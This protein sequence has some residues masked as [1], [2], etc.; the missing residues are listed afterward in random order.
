MIAQVKEE[1]RQDGRLM[2]HTR[3]VFKVVRI[4]KD[5][6][7]GT[8]YRPAVVYDMSPFENM[9]YKPHSYYN[10]GVE[11]MYPPFAYYNE[12]DAREFLNYQCAE[13][14]DGFGVISRVA[15][16]W[17]W[18][19][20]YLAFTDYFTSDLDTFWNSVFP[21]ARIPRQAPPTYPVP[22]GSIVMFE[23]EI[24]DRVYGG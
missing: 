24:G 9:I 16:K 7:N 20:R 2:E 21:Y 6:N 10:I 11:F 17:A 5:Y 14:K 19:R 8:I 22:T 3:T 13:D 12:I 4:E 23:F 18:V 15:Y 1:L